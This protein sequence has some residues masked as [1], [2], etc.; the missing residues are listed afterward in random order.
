MVADSKEMDGARGIFTT[1]FP[2]NRGVWWVLFEVTIMSIVIINYKTNN[3]FFKIKTI[4]II[5]I[6]VYYS[7]WLFIIQIYTL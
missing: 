5:I 3:I 4:I 6:V 1:L 7:M 2:S